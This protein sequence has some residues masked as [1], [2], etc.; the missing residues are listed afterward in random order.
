MN[1]D[2]IEAQWQIIKGQ[3]RERFGKLT[4]GDLQTV[5]EKN[6]QLVGMIQ[7]QYGVTKK[8]RS[9]ISKNLFPIST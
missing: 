8:K 7:K 1:L 6:D 2:Q 3:F 5:A 4:D 9:K